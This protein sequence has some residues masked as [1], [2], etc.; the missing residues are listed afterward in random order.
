MAI[1]QNPNF[2]LSYELDRIIPGNRVLVVLEPIFSELQKLH[3]KG[4]PKDQMHSR[5]A[6]EFVNKHCQQWPSEYSHRNIDFILLHYGKER[7]GIIATNDRKLK[8]MALKKGI[9]ILY[10]RSQRFLELQ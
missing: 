2:N 6:I 3:Q 10:I 1:S 8:R 4:N 7:K 9:K 5:L